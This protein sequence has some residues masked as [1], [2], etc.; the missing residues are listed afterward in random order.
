VLFRSHVQNWKMKP[1]LVVGILGFFGGLTGIAAAEGNNHNANRRAHSVA[2]Q[3]RI[4]LRSEHFRFTNL[5]GY[6][7]S[8]TLIVGQCRIYAEISQLPSRH[9][10]KKKWRPTVF[11]GSTGLEASDLPALAQVC[12]H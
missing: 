11:G 6:N 7:K 2:R 5:D 8:L 12:R 3:A 10:T 1:I 9:D 4:D